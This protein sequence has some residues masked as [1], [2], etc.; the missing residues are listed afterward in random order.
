[1]ADPGDLAGI[2]AG[3]ALLERLQAAAEG[4]GRA[5]RL[6]EILVVRALALQRGGRADDAL[7]VLQTA[8][9]LAEPEGYVRVFADEGEPMARLLAALAKRAGESA[10]L[11]GLRAA[12][13][14][15]RPARP[16]AQG[17]IDPLS[18]RELDVLR[19]LASDLGG[20]EIASELMVSLNTFRTHTKNI[21]AKLGVTSRREAVRR[22]AELGIVARR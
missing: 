14:G 5:G 11:R 13:S 1:V 2:R 3:S 15:A 16:D 20:P 4:G 17:L 9:D 22:A 12:A 7:D 21:Y 19:L 10:Y 8:V 6:L 18:H